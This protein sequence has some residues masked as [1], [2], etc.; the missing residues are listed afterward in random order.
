MRDRQIEAPE[1]Y[2]AIQTHRAIMAV[3]RSQLVSGRSA[4]E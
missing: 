4:D 3:L 1:R 2:Q